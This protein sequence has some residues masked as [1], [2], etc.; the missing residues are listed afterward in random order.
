MRTQPVVEPFPKI[1]ATANSD[2]VARHLLTYLL[3]GQILPGDKLPSERELTEAFG[4]GRSAVREAIKSFSMLGIVEVRQGSGAYLK[5]T[6]SDLLPKVIEWGLL[7]GERRID[8][9][10]EARRY[11]EPI[12][13]QLA[14]VRRTDAAILELHE[15]LER[16]RSASSTDAFVAADIDFHM[17]L[18]QA[19]GNSILSEVLRSIRALLEVWI[20][21][22]RDDRS[23]AEHQA[24]LE[25]IVR[26]DPAEAAS[27]MTAHMDA[28]SD[29]LRQSVQR[30]EAVDGHRPLGMPGSTSPPEGKKTARQTSGSGFDR[31]SGTARNES[32]VHPS[33]SE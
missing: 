10:V 25:A 6:N 2:E 1:R 26:A 13:A 18:A 3:S 20:R 24:V 33:G 19:G 17:L 5:T 15:A 7:L 29:K 12:V 9:L 23:V 11:L 16:M 31:P 14:A 21:R 8:D 27:A 32:A 4:V 28:A 22:A 30:D